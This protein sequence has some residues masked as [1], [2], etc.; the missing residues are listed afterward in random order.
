[1]RQPTCFIRYSPRRAGKLV[2]SQKLAGRGGWLRFSG[3][4][5]LNFQKTVHSTQLITW[6]K[7][8]HI[9][10][11]MIVIDIDIPDTPRAKVYRSSRSFNRQELLGKK[12]INSRAP[13]I[14]RRK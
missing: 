11:N 4:F 14:A 7:T 10:T 1:M 2:G 5:E 3:E 8:Q 6:G 13:P 12:P 9:R